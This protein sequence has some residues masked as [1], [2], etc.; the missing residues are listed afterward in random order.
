MRDC[1]ATA[2]GILLVSPTSIQQNERDRKERKVF[3]SLLFVQSPWRV[4][5]WFL[6]AVYTE[7]PS[8]RYFVL[9]NIFYI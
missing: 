2:D 5:T 1:L 8:E 3:I 4:L 7:R 6:R 9:Q